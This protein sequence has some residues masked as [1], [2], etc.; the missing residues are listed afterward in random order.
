MPEVDHKFNLPPLVGQM[1]CVPRRR[2]VDAD[3]GGVGDVAGYVRAQFEAEPVRG[4][5][6]LE[7]DEVKMRER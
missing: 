7:R 5:A 6:D 1:D 2:I 3:V 4:E